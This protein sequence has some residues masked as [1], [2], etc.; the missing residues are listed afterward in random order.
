MRVSFFRTTKE[1]TWERMTWLLGK[2]LTFSR[3]ASQLSAH[4]AD[5]IVICSL[6]QRGQWIMFSLL[7]DWQW[8]ILYWPFVDLLLT[9]T[10]PRRSVI[11]DDEP[12]AFL[13]ACHRLLRKSGTLNILCLW[14]QQG[15]NIRGE[16]ADYHVI[17]SFV[18][19]TI[20]HVDSHTTYDSIKI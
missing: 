5:L 10:G 14:L 15:S 20:N 1:W 19:S 11:R 8:R 4:V 12:I 17:Q 16:S 18:V 3:Y 9:T 7:F 2:L 6:C 13:S